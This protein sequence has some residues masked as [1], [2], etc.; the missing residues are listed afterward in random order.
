MIKINSDRIKKGLETVSHRALLRIIGLKD[1]DFGEKPW[2]GV[3]N[4]YTNLIPGHLTLNDA[5]ERIMQGIIDAGGVAFEWGVPGICDGIAMGKGNGMNYSLPSRNNIADNI[6]LMMSGH[7]L[8]AWVGVTNCDKITPGM[9]MAT[10]RLNLPAIIFTGG[11]MKPAYIDGK[12]VDIRDAYE[13]VGSFKAGTMSEEEVLKIEKYCCPGPGACAGLYTANSMACM[14]EILGLSLTGCAAMHAEDPKKLELAYETGKQIVKLAKEDIKPRDIIME[15]SFKNTIMVDLCIGGS[16]NTTLHIPEIAKEY[17]LDVGLFMFDEL[18][19]E[20]PNLVKINPSSDYMMDDFD[21]AGGIPAVMKRLKNMLELDVQTVNLKTI[22]EIANEAVVKDDDMI[23]PIENAYSKTGALAIIKGNLCPKGAV[24]KVAAVD[25][26]ML[27]HEG[28][29]RV[30]NSEYDAMDAI[31]NKKIKPGDVVVIRFMGKKGAPGMPEMLNPT[32][33]IAGMG[34]ADSV[35]L[36]TDGRFSGVT[37]GPCIGHIDPEGWDGGPI[38]A[39][40]EGDTIKIDLL[41]RTLD[42]DLPD[43]TI[44]RR[45]KDFKAPPRKLKGILRNYVNNLSN[46]GQ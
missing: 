28:P 36:I 41:S 39:I 43:E 16:T 35:A 42:L 34:L 40:E 7:S 4:S 8:D 23:R 13:A 29:A 5:T 17:E 24:I 45:I 1:E 30:F 31:L 44:K 38:I 37:R 33:A 3:A 14:T 2:I 15:K 11:P 18:A 10:G 9:L 46:M 20:T 32:S 22:G 25:K 6:E 19:K 27:Q 26:K 12:K 21:R